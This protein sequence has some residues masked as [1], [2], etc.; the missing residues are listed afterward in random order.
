MLQPSM[1]VKPVPLNKL[2]V[3]VLAPQI[4]S[5]DPNINYYYDF[6]Q[7]IAEYTKTFSELNIEWVWQPVTMN[8]FCSVIDAIVEEK[9]SKKSFPVVFNI[10]DGDE[11]NGTPGVSVVKML[12]EKGLI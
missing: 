9:K 1:F 11:I 7:S 2:K 6:S 8:T 5:V 12:E 3:W 10:C 4:D